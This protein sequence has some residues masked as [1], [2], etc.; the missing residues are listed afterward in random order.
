MRIT[1]DP[2]ADAVYVT[3]RD[4]PYAFGETLDPDRRIDYG[5]DRKPIGIELL[6][7]HRGVNVA[8]LPHAEEIARRLRDLGI[9]VT[10]VSST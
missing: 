9:P 7:V 10:S 2:E 3:L 8:D 4:V 6:N 5:R 1:Y